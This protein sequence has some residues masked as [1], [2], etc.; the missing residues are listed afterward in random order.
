MFVQPEDCDAEKVGT[1]DLEVIKNANEEQ[2]APTQVIPQRSRK[3]PRK[4]A[5][6]EQ[7]PDNEVGPDGEIMHLAMFENVEPVDYHVSLKDKSWKKAMVEE[8]SSIEKNKT[9]E[10]TKLLEGKK[11]IGL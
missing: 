3:L 8:L 11:A 10:L 1:E 4:L 2:V 9:W 5:D 6:Y 7:V